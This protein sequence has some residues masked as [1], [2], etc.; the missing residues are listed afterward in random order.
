MSPVSEG[1]GSALEFALR[2]QSDIYADVIHV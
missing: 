2:I 1:V